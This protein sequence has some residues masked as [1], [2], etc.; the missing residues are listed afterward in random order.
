MKDTLHRRDERRDER[1]EVQAE[2][3]NNLLSYKGKAAAWISSCFKIQKGGS[4]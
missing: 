2:H 3:A 1:E 4:S